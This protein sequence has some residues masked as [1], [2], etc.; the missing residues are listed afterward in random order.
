MMKYLANFTAYILEKKTKKVW[1]YY[2][3]S[4]SVYTCQTI[5]PVKHRPLTLT[6]MRNRQ[7]VHW[8]NVILWN[9]TSTAVLS[10]Q[11]L[12]WERLYDALGFQ[13]T[14]LPRCSFRQ[15]LCFYSWCV[16]LIPLS[17]AKLCHLDC[18]LRLMPVMVQNVYV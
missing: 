7:T 11:Y 5:R 15:S 3:D 1:L 2:S 12:F 4:K 6:V 18:C 16:K 9:S 17:S 14:I 13:K 10:E 8:A